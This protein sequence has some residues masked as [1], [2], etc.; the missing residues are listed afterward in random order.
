MSE[1]SCPKRIYPKIA[2]LLLLIDEFCFR[3]DLL[4][5]SDWG[6]GYV[7]ILI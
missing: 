4:V 5:K 1:R 2:M 3:S 7:L 6:F